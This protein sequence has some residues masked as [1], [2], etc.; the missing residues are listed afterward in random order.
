M[1]FTRPTLEELNTRMQADIE[2][3]LTDGNK[4][5][6]R[7][8]LKIIATVF[9]AAVHLLYGF[10][11]WVYKQSF[12][13]TAEGEN[14]ERWANIWGITRIPAEF[15]QGNVT[16][17][18]DNGTDIPAS[19]E[20]QLSNGTVYTTDALGT[21]AA[22]T[23]TIAV[24]ASVAG[25]DSDAEAATAISLSS[26][27]S[28]VTS[29]G[30][31]ATGGLTG[32]LVEESDED[33]LTRLLARIQ[34][35]PHGGNEAD[36]VAWAKEVAGVTRAWVLPAYL[37]LGTVGVTFVRDNDTGSIIPSAGEVSDVQDY[38]DDP[39]RRPVTADV[40]VFA[41]TAVPLNFTINVTPGTAAVKAAVEAELEDLI[42]REAE[43][44]G[45]ILLTHIEEAISLAAGETDHILTVPSGDVT[46]TSTQ[47][48][49]MGVI[50]W[51]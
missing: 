47:L 16:F 28:G 50:T 24:T 34:N 11:N 5:L 36:Y 38:I 29:Q 26:P 20:I 22:G 19:T 48:S 30:V 44:G 42:L 32:G 40:T 49:T 25:P 3:R 33:L 1:A 21:I 41:P 4:L 31:V 27:I 37:G 45:T 18:G 15:S 17:T 2:S 10:L 6:R 43:P 7:S 14:L 9:A 51:V 13:D 12:P 35:A 8:V 39:S 46:V 23:V